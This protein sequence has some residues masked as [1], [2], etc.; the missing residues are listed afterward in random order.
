MDEANIRT[1]RQ[2]AFVR[3]LKSYSFKI[4][5]LR[6][7]RGD[8]VVITLILSHSSKDYMKDD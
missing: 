4:L 3:K 7:Q 1:N 8:E 5:I 6:M 2:G